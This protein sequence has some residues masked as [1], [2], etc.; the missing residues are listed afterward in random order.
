MS[1]RARLAFVTVI[2]LVGCIAAIPS[3]RNPT[4]QPR[5]TEDKVS[6]STLSLA[7]TPSAEEGT[8]KGISADTSTQEQGDDT[9]KEKPSIPPLSQDDSLQEHSILLQHPKMASSSTAPETQTEDA[10]FPEVPQ[11]ESA[12]VDAIPLNLKSRDLA[13]EFH[14]DENQLQEQSSRWNRPFARS[15]VL[16]AA[17]EAESLSPNVRQ[18]VESRRDR[19][20]N[21]FGDAVDRN[22]P[23]H[24]LQPTPIGARA[25]QRSQTMYSSSNHDLPAESDKSRNSAGSESS[26]HRVVNGDT[27]EKIAKQYY[28]DSRRAINIFEANRAELYNPAILPIGADLRI[29]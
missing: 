1:A 7:A 21:S 24:V 19:F 20:S 12:S 28:G 22:E 14:A 18:S 2:I 6:G 26:W 17:R 9:D 10:K 29:P 13:T 15:D 16:R 23:S 5:E 8:A 4:G 27:L 25:T 11:Q 3:F